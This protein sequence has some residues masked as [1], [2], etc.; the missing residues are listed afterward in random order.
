MSTMMG[1]MVSKLSAEDVRAMMGEMM[2]Q[3][4]GRMGPEERVAFMGSMLEVCIPK[5]T[6]GMDH[7]GKGRIVREFLEILGRVATTDG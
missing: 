7:Q 3:I 5:L 2:G 6:E 1:K 4:F